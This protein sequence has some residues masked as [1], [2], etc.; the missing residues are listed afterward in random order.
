ERETVLGLQVEVIEKR[1]EEEKKEKRR[2]RR[3]IEREEEER[4]RTER[5]GQKG[6]EETL[7]ENAQLKEREIRSHME[8]FI[9]KGAVEKEQLDRRRAEEEAADAREALQKTRDS[10]VSLVSDL[11]LLKRQ[12][13]ETRDSL[14]KMA[15][16][17][18]SL[19]KDKRELNTHIL[20]MEAELA[21]GHDQL[22][23]LKSEV[24]SLQR[25]LRV[26]SQDY[27]Q[28]KSQ[29]ETEEEVVLH[30]RERE[31]AMERAGQERRESE[32]WSL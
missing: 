10:E 2:I 29:M 17:N 14:D 28:L 12:L 20:Q 4:R 6:V 25:N 9:L 18:Q 23:V 27:N 3:E 7:M 15:T 1:E 21:D 19:A 13:A 32:R 31:D 16:L 26:L 11:N 8:I 30:L 22:R 24:T 5:E